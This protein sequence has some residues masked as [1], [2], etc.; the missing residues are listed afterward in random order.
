MRCIMETYTVS[1]FG[2]RHISNSFRADE[3]IEKIVSDILLNKEYTEFLIGRDGDFD[4]LAASAIKRTVKKCGYDNSAL[5]LVL[6]YMKAEYKN[7]YDSF[8][9]YY[10]DVEICRESSEAHFKAA[11][12]IRNKHMIDRSDLIVCCI[13]KNSGG[14][15]KSVKYADT[16]NKNIINVADSPIFSRTF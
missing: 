1:F 9:D 6:P 12:Q 11:V 8:H 13:E 5:V 15:Y 7:N 3:Q 16:I 14:A 2:H 4:I 10:D